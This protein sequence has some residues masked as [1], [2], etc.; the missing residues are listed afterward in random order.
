MINDGKFFSHRYLKMKQF[1]IIYFNKRT[2]KEDENG[3]GVP[4]QRSKRKEVQE[5]SS[6]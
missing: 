1:R 3:R 2:I 6:S 4:P 5:F